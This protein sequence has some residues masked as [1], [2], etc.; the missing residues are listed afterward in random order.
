MKNII[1]ICSLATLVA[2][3]SNHSGN[4]IINGS[5]EL[6]RYDSTPVGWINDS[7]HWKSV[8]GDSILHT[9]ALAQ[10]GKYH[11]FEGEDLSGILS[12]SIDVGKY[13]TSIDKHKQQFT[14]S[15]FVQVFPQVPP[16]QCE[17]KITCL[18]TPGGKP[19][20]SFSSDTISSVSKWQP[21]KDTFI[22]PASTRFIQIQLIAQ[23]RNGADNDGYFD[24][25]SLVALPTQNYLL[26]II[27]IAIVIVAISSFAYFRKKMINKK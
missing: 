27:V 6:P 5:A 20:Y 10:D 15:G 12:Q 17:I 25:I 7:G 21:V 22:A 11:F 3:N 4:L 19:L 24:N 1:Y 18:Q 16:D 2:C 9:Y 26:I 13:S 23:R 14:F 8:E